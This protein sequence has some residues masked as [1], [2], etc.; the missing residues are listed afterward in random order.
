[1]CHR[2][3]GRLER[4]GAWLCRAWSVRAREGAPESARASA[5]DLPQREERRAGKGQGLRERV[6]SQRSR[7]GAPGGR[8]AADAIH[9]QASRKPFRSHDHGDDRS[10]RA[11]DS[12]PVGARRAHADRREYRWAIPAS[13]RWRSSSGRLGA[14]RCEGRCDEAPEQGA[15]RQ[16]VERLDLGRRR[17]Y[18][19]RIRYSLGAVM[20]GAVAGVAIPFGLHSTGRDPAYGSSVLLTF[21]TDTMGFFLFLGLAAAFFSEGCHLCESRLRTSSLLAL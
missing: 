14:I 2:S 6:H 9:P 12:R 13:R 21:I 18:C 8:R 4:R 17:W 19:G 15:R 5:L 11:H 7:P 16:S 20:T 1:M 3:G 10:V